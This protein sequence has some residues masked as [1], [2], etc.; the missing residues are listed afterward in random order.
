MRL[1]I[2]IP[3][4]WG[5]EDP[6]ALVELAVR[7]E[8]AG[9]DAVWTSEHL[10][11]TSYVRSR[12]GERPYHHPL[13]ILSCIAGRTTRIALAT[14]VIVLPFHN[15]FDIAK[16]V[17]TLDQ[18]SKGRVIFGVG[19]GNVPEEFAALNVPWNK[20]GAMTDEAIA[21]IRTL[22]AETSA[23][24][25]GEFWTFSDVHTSPK[26]FT[27]RK[28]P[29]WIGGM[30]E[31]ALKRT[32]RVGDGWQ[33]TA[34][35]PDEF[36]QQAETI[37]S[38]AR[39]YGRDPAAIRLCMRFNLALDGAVV[40]DVERR[41]TVAGDDVKGMIETARSF[42]AAGATDFIFA[43][44]SHDPRTLEHTVDTLAREVLPHCA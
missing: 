11:N 23:S 2:S 12:I 42:A 20:R 34:I 9:L 5:V 8:E 25:R 26:P 41:S 31:A 10:I 39:S 30:S 4:N 1:G 32:A 13:A 6:L 44:N 37:R 43:L 36:R 19:V 35:S 33:P 21:V 18:L 38:L 22:W 28:I 15:P 7:A 3:N 17:A 29:I 27:G 24:H 16:Y 14:S 40:T